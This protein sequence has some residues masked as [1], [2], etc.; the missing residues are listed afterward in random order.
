MG[1][2]TRFA[3]RHPRLAIA[4]WL[5]AVLV[6]FGAGH[7]LKPRYSDN[8]ALA[9]SQAER[10]GDLLAKA[11]PAERG[12][13][14]PVV[15]LARPPYTFAG[16]PAKTA[17]LSLKRR[18]AAL[19]GVAEV[20]GDP[21]LAD[22]G[23]AALLTVRLAG[24]QPPEA[25]VR[26]VIGT[27]RSA[28]GRQAIAAA[29]A[30]GRAV[31]ATEG[32]SVDTATAVGLLAALAVLLI[33]FG[34]PLA[35]ALPIL[36]ALAGLGAASG[37]IAAASRA[38]EMPSFS[39][40][41]A[42][43]VGLGVGI[44]YALF[45]LNRYRQE[46]AEG[47][48]VET[49]VGR[50]MSTAGRA[51]LLAGL[52]VVASLLGM[53]LLGAG[54][55]SGAAL[56]SAIAVLAVVAASVTLLPALLAI[57]GRRLVRRPLTPARILRRDGWRWWSAALLRRPLLFAVLGLCAVVVLISPVG[58]LQLGFS[59][60]GEGRP[61][62]QSYRAYS[63][64]AK[65]F[66][67]GADA[68]IEVV[69]RS[70][71]PGE[72]PAHTLALLRS[73]LLRGGGVA[74]VSP[75]RVD[76]AGNVAAIS[77]QPSGGP[78]A[79]STQALVER[80]RYALLPA[81][82][83]AAPLEALVGGVTAASLDFST[84]LEGRLPLFICTVSAF[85]ALL[86]LLVFRSPLLAIKASLLNLLAIGASLGIVVAVFQWGLLGSLSPFGRG[87]IE[88]FLP[89]MVFAIVYGLSMD[90]EVFLLSRIHERY[91]AGEDARAATAS[92]LALSGP[93]ITAAAAIMVCVFCSFIAGGERVIAEFGLAL[94][95]AIFLDAGLIRCLL[96][97]SL[98]GLFGEQ[99]WRGP[100][101]L[102]RLPPLL[103][104]GERP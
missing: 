98:L 75:V 43:M 82:E 55:L 28:A 91:H 73:A 97:P 24:Q 96:I 45:L 21:R 64:I 32:S 99:A 14:V 39:G 11:F 68:P 5:V 83:E 81:L 18:L 101:L 19:G 9:G 53:T 2:V 26:K 59:D 40:E 87:P 78:Q 90:Y 36:S 102:R 57:C 100:A 52:T 7:Q 61:G 92:G 62:S 33:T 54:I 29:A 69:V 93:V 23:R 77:I 42:A 50:A 49:A 30:G 84:A 48:D 46:L 104:E 34:S 22:H 60:G 41:L 67:P 58:S 16:G 63:L 79:R 85:A 37:L 89:V 31:E 35:A 66:G 25:V 17:L 15:L 65:E 103:P 12:E 47:A 94:A 80:L 72:Q 3:S 4:G 71:R 10:A 38:F 70:L 86:L 56:A 44:D 88:S 95:S 6:L 1:R 51:V 74:A 20:A 8:L 13:T 27:V 76:A